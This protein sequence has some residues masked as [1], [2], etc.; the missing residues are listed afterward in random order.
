MSWLPHQAS[1]PLELILIVFLLSLA[2]CPSWDPVVLWQSSQR[3]ITV[4][5]TLPDSCCGFLSLS[6]ILQCMRIRG[7]ANHRGTTGQLGI[8]TGLPFLIWVF[9]SLLS[10]EVKMVWI[11]CLLLSG[12]PTC[13][14]SWA[15]KSAAYAVKSSSWEKAF[16]FFSR[17]GNALEK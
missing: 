10:T 16:L 17:Y 2:F 8:T 1:S 15:W 3:G 5:A 13:G 14:A 11:A 9:K 7:Q 4:E 12:F 6:A